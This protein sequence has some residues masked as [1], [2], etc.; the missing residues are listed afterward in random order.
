MFSQLLPK[1]AK[2]EILSIFRRKRC[3]PSKAFLMFFLWG[4]S[5]SSVD[6]SRFLS[7]C[8]AWTAQGQ[9]L[10]ISS[11]ASYDDKKWGAFSSVFFFKH[12]IY[13]IGCGINTWFFLDDTFVFSRN[14]T[15]FVILSLIFVPLMEGV[16]VVT[17]WKKGPISR[18]R[19]QWNGSTSR[20]ASGFCDSKF[21]K[22]WWITPL[23]TNMS[24]E[25]Q[26]LED[27]FPIEIVPC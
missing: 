15:G 9:C 23:K 20:G 11:H 4:G 24:P 16:N 14:A 25:N 5:W 26:W 21:L 12:L 7:S 27:V 8:P 18:G 19:S 3:F 10:G 1:D 22:E 17:R 6:P 2:K 13:E